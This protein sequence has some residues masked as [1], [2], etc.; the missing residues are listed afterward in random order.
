MHL[1]L[2]PK[3]HFLNSSIKYKF[4]FKIYCNYTLKAL[5]E[6]KIK[7]DRIFKKH[8]TPKLF[9]LKCKKLNYLSKSMIVRDF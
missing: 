6:L 9:F 8:I 2:K 3:F 4:Y 5:T 1:V 7:N